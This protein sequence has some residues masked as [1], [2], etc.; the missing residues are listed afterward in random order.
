MPVVLRRGH[1]GNF[2]DELLSQHV[3]C[4]NMAV[5]SMTPAQIHALLMGEPDAEDVSLLCCMVTD[6]ASEDG[7]PLW[8]AAVTPNSHICSSDEMLVVPLSAQWVRGALLRAISAFKKLEFPE[9][10][11][12]RKLIAAHRSARGAHP[13]HSLATLQCNTPKVACV[14][15]LH[16]LLA[17]HAPPRLCP[18]KRF[19]RFDSAAAGI[20]CK[21]QR[22]WSELPPDLQ[23]T[24]VHFCVTDGGDYRSLR[25]VCRA[26]RFVVDKQVGVV[27]KLLVA[28]VSEV[29]AR[30]AHSV[31]MAAAKMGLRPVHLFA[32]DGASARGRVR[33]CAS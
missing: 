28:A 21:K 26:F 6:L 15:T 10:S 31:G 4:P 13:A 32:M 7:S 16:A 22:W 14:R 5:Q 3:L 30:R 29:D 9:N 11:M 17:V 12:L 25:A 23:T 24:I 1:A 2:S 27:K 18:A 33:A 8:C 20:C 19:S